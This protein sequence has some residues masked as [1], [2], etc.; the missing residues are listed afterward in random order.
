MPRRQARSA[1][2][3]AIPGGRADTACRRSRPAARQIRHP[4]ARQIRHPIA[5]QIR[6]PIARQ[7]R[8][9]ARSPDSGD[10]LLLSHYLSQILPAVRPVQVVGASP[11]RRMMII[12][13]PADPKDPAPATGSAPMRRLARRQGDRWAPRR[14]P[15]TSAG[16]CP[17]RRLETAARRAR[18]LRRVRPDR[19]GADRVRGA[20]LGLP[21]RDQQPPTTP[22]DGEF[23]F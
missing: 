4:I 16:L 18:P 1:R 3:R 7:I 9:P 8:R 12:L 6:H 23:P 2:V 17:M 14:P 19:P 11:P 21:G 13:I 22:G 20:V 15:P 5:R 10:L